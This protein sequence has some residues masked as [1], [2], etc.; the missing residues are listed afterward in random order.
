MQAV[1]R[2]NLLSLLANYRK[3]H[4]S[5]A[6][7]IDQYIAFVQT[8][9]N[10]FERSLLSGHVTGSAWLVN[11]DRKQVL[12]THHKKLN[13]WLQLGG[14]ADGDSDI[15]AVALRE[16]EEES[17]L[18]DIELASRGIFDIDI[19]V[20]PAGKNEPEHLHY[21]LR[22][23]FRATGNQEYVLS[24]ESNHESPC[25]PLARLA[26]QKKISSPIR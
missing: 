16:A 23:A 10:C 15:L 26:K 12:L 2:K 18:V 3:Q 14:H 25:K 4:S 13:C 1:H 7:A 9:A 6:F 20:I 19:H 22:F 24:E 8:N 21:D 11:L 5:E 17:G